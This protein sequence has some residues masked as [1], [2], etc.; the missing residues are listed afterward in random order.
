MPMQMKPL[1]LKPDGWFGYE[2]VDHPNQTFLDD[3]NQLVTKENLSLIADGLLTS[4]KDES[5][6]LVD[7]LHS[8][9]LTNQSVLWW[10]YLLPPTAKAQL[11]SVLR[12]A[13]AEKL[14]LVF[15]LS[16]DPNHS[17]VAIV[18]ANVRQRHVLPVVIVVGPGYLQLQE[19]ENQA[20]KWT[21][22][23]EPI[24]AMWQQMSSRNQQ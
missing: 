22:T 21:P 8:Q 12:F 10:I 13:L 17:G 1:E 7:A 9:G 20:T 6:S 11:R 18:A 4:L 3:A 2:F 14:G 23:E 19:Q 5:T 24:R 16:F 15:G